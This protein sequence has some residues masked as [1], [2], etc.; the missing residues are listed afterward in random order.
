MTKKLLIVAGAGEV[1]FGLLLLVSPALAAW[2]LLGIHVSGN[3]A[4]GGRVVGACLVT[5][6][7]GCWPRS[8]SHRRATVMMTYSALA[9][10]SLVVVGLRWSAGFLL[11]PATAVHAAI[12][13]WLWLNRHD[14]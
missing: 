12:A 14:K 9:A 11:W 6:G 1:A 8:D 10:C 7:I 13:M 4:V 3:P 2:W 5:L